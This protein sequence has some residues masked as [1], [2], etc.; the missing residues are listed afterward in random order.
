[1]I[2]D[3]NSR[4]IGIDLG[5]ANVLAYVKGKG[6]IA[7]EPSVVA[8]RNDATRE[9]LAVGEAAKA[10]IGRTPENILAV[11]P[12]QEGVI[13]DFD[14]TE[15]MLRY[16]IRQ[17]IGGAFTIRKPVVVICVPFGVTEVERNAVELSAKKAGAR[18]V[19][20][21]EEPIAAAIGAGLPVQDAVGSM[22]VDIGGGTTEVAVMSLGG[23]VVCESLR[24]GGNKFDEAIVAYLK[25]ERNLA[26]GDR[27]A[28]EIKINIGTAY[29]LEQEVFM[30]VR[31]RDLL[32]GLPVTVKLSSN[33]IY[34]ALKDSVT[35]IVNAIKSTLE[36]TPPELSS[37][38]MARGITLTGGSSLLTGLDVL[39]AQETGIRCSVDPNPLDCVVKGCGKLV[40]EG[41]FLNKIIA[42]R[43]L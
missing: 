7:R 30:D 41:D 17:A 15:A 37:D 39:V 14:A 23:I 29:P 12:L 31:G 26:I 6:I 4:D 13:A 42:M 11:R 32:D 8:V 1:M 28:E 21:V 25:Q 34:D 33:S 3:F 19:I 18:A 27:T 43:T 24:V 10:M 20:M 22:V 5:T 9:I 16:Y 35:Q 2:F 38:I 40:E 36:K